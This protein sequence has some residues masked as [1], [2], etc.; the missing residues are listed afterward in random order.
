M[1]FFLNHN[2]SKHTSTYGNIHKKSIKKNLYY[3][4]KI[5]PEK[6]NENVSRMIST[7]LIL[8]D[9]DIDYCV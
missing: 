5:F 7:E 1:Y 9:I 4:Q 8:K 6:K 2:Y 3:N